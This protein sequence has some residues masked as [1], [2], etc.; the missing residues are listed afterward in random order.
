MFRKTVEQDINQIMEIIKQAQDYFKRNHIDQ[1]QNNYPNRQTIMGDILKGY[2]YVLVKNEN[3]VATTA[4]SF[5]GEKTYKNIYNGKWLSN[6]EYAVIHRLAV[7][8][9]YKGLG[10]SSEILKHVEKICQDNGIHSIKVDTHEQNLSM[11]KLL[12]KNEFTYCG[13]IYLEDNSKRI[14]FEKMF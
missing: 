5:D 6:D 4:I 14:A 7:H 8:S 12:Q 13:E 10:I 11:Q 3:I 2:A 1:W 9:H